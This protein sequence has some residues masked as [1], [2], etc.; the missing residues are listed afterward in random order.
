MQGPASSPSGSDLP[1]SA[2]QS[3]RFAYGSHQHSLLLS[4]DLS[5]AE[6][7]SILRAVFKLKENVVG[8]F[9]PTRQIVRTNKEASTMQ[10]TPAM[11][12]NLQRRA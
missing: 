5:A 4:P 12:G 1:S 3:V 9:E 8:I 10:S 6:A 2:L 11:P 7:Q